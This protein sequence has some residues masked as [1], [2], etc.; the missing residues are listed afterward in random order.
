MRS[1]LRALGWLVREWVPW[2]LVRVVAGRDYDHTAIQPCAGPYLSDTPE[3]PDGLAATLYRVATGQDWD[4][5]TVDIQQDWR[6][7]AQELID[8][9]WARTL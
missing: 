4:R 6:A 2:Q 7:R 5:A 3:H 8:E 9:G 1:R